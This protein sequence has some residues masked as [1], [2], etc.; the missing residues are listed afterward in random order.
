MGKLRACIIIA[1]AALATF[2]ACG[3][4]DKKPVDALIIVPDAPPD[5]KVWMD[6]PPDAAPVFDLACLGSAAPTTTTALTITVSGSAT[7]VSLNGTTPQFAP[8]AGATVDGCVLGA[9]NC[10]GGNQLG[11]STTGSDGSFSIGPFPTNGSAVAAYLHLTPPSG[12]ASGSGDKAILEYPAEPLTA[13]FSGVPLITFAPSALTALAFL[14]CNQTFATKGMMAVLVTDCSN[15]PI[16]DSA[17]TVV[18]I[19]QGGSA[20]G[21]A[22]IDLGNL[23]AMAAGTY[24]ICN[25]PPSAMTHV[26]VT[27]K[28]MA[29][30]TND[31]N[32]V[33]QTITAAQI[34]P[35]G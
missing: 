21:D 14:G 13:D 33:T 30:R 12:S 8:L 1:S 22:P 10:N 27:Y 26:A 31:V 3:S 35:G 11:T 15:R 34:R 24:L 17:N 28:S 23:N 18:A 6:A 29:F 4:S 7:E 19:T 20:V 32:V 9:A 25:V 16:S 5:A 2:V